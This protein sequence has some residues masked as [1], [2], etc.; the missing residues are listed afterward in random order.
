MG[1]EIALLHNGFLEAGKHRFMF[2]DRDFRPAPAPIGLMQ[3][4]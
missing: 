1:E 3:M 2:E 4:A